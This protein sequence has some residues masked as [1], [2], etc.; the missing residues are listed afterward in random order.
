MYCAPAFDV[1]RLGTDPRRKELA[2]VG[3]VSRRGNVTSLEQT[4]TGYSA[5]VFTDFEG[6]NGAAGE[7]GVA[8]FDGEAF[9][10]GAEDDGFFGDLGFEE[11][12]RVCRET[13]LSGEG[14]AAFAG[15]EKNLTFFEI[16]TPAG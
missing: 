10:V 2:V 8:F 7:L 9:F 15:G 6:I 14:F 13:G 16:E 11:A 5:T 4:Q 1:R 12:F 3:R